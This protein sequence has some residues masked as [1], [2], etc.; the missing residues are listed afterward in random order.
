MTSDDSIF[1]KLFEL[2]QSPG[3]VNWRLAAE[4]RKSLVGAAEPVDPNLADEY[5]ELGTAASMRLEPVTA[6]PTGSLAAIQPVDRV[7][8]AEDN[9]ESFGY[10]V[11][12][13]AGKFG[14]GPAD[15]ANPMAAMLAPMGPAVLGMQAGTMVGFMAHRVLGQ[16]DTGLPALGSDRLYLVVPNVEGFAADHGLDRRQVR[17]WAACHE[18]A[19]RAILDIPW[20]R[21]RVVE[22]VAD[23][24]ATVRFDPSRIT[25]TLEHMDDPAALQ[26]AIGGQAGGLAGLLGSEH[27]PGKLEP[28]RALLAAIEGYGD[29]LTRLALDGIA[30]ELSRIEE[31][32]SSR[33]AEPDQAGELLGQL[34]GLSPDRAGAADAA[35]FFPDITRRWSGEAVDRVWSSPEAVPTVAELTDPVGWAARVL[36]EGGFGEAPDRPGQ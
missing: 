33:R 22:L 35:R 11:E 9:Q 20:V 17:L 12:P 32:W 25:E 16:F 29:H 30:P 4:V 5:A 8:W 13:L 15:P 10:A 7:V 19:H 34:V 24:E 6:L 27:D 18:V 36:L 21:G 1:S 2:F 28:I 3:P 14:A 26:E 31:A 23:F